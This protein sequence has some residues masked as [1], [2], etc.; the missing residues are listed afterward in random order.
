VIR[1]ALSRALYVLPVVALLALAAV[2]FKS[3]NGPPPDEL[4]SA[5]IDKPAPIVD[6]PPLD[7][8]TPAFKSLDLTAGHVSIVNVWASWCVP[9]RVE[10]PA[11]AALAHEQGVAL[12]GVVYKDTPAKARAFLDDVGNPFSRI[13]LDADGRAGIEWGIYGVPET[14]VIDG[15]GI[16]RLRFAGPLV[17]DTLDR[18]ILP[19]IRQAQASG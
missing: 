3:L 4:P 19:A 13:D 2:F 6:L 7:A 18:T 12:Y 16:V 15:K 1:K 10:A 17:G 5:L 9:C 11:L 14:F 8:S